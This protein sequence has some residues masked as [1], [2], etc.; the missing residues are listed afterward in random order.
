MPRPLGKGERVDELGVLFGLRLEVEAEVVT[1]CHAVA[2]GVHINVRAAVVDR[3]D[4]GLARGER[5]AEGDFQRSRVVGEIEDLAAG[6]DGAHLEGL[7]IER[8]PAEVLLREQPNLR[9]PLHAPGPFVQIEGDPVVEDI[10]RLVPE[11][12]LRPVGTVLERRRLGRR[13]LG[14]AGA[15]RRSQQGGRQQGDGQ[16]TAGPAAVL[17]HDAQRDRSRSTPRW[18][19]RGVPRVSI[20]VRA[21]TISA[22]SRFSPAAKTL[23]R[24]FTG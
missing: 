4:E 14:R 18:M 1:R 23:K 9:L 13:R 10:E 19:A 15:E 11:R 22:S 17:A 5:L 3:K 2:G 12:L 21:E 16:P 20:G 8:D 6:A 7:R 24:S